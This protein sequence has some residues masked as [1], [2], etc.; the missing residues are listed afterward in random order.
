MEGKGEACSRCQR[1]CTFVAEQGCV[2]VAGP[3]MWTMHPQRLHWSHG[4]CNTL[5]TDMAREQRAAPHTYYPRALTMTYRTT[6]PRMKQLCTDICS[7]GTPKHALSAP[8]CCSAMHKSS[9]VLHHHLACC[10]RVI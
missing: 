6:D 9:A 5:H 3:G 2:A 10:W 4:T 8:C 7:T 1:R